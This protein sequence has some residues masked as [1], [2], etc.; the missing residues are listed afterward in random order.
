MGGRKR[1]R[2]GWRKE[3][4]RK[5]KMEGGENEGR[6]ERR[7]DRWTEEWSSDSCTTQQAEHPSSICNSS[8][9]VRGREKR[10]TRVCWHAV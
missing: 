1:G 10:I 2:R 9:E 5:E 8:M 4:R 3:K 6:R 7:K